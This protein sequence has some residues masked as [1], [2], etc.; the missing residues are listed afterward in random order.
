MTDHLTTALRDLAESEPPHGLDAERIM[1]EG[2]RGEARRRMA[3]L[4][5][6]LAVLV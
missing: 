2:R 3:A 5:A 1:H 6:G 4:G